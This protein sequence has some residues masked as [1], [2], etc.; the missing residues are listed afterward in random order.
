MDGRE[1]CRML[2]EL[3]DDIARQNGIEIF[4][5]ACTYEGECSGTRPKCDAETEALSRA[6]ERRRIR[7]SREPVVIDPDGTDELMGESRAFDPFD[8]EEDRGT[9][10]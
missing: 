9:W 10:I 5:E 6:L 7:L 4:R 2:R 8:F 1:K 3:R